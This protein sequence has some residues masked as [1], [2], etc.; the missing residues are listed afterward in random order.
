MNLCQVRKPRINILGTELSGVI[1]A[2]GKDVKLFKA[3]DPVFGTPSASFG[4]HAEYTCMPE[5]GELAIKPDNITFEE[6]AAVFFGA[7]TALFYLRNKGDIQA[8]QKILIIGA[9]QKVL[10]GCLMSLHGHL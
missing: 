4:A 5:D 7:H 8:G 10:L 2:V 9:N 3:G 1:E 6:A